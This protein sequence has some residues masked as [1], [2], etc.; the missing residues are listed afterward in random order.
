MYAGGLGVKKDEAKAFQL[1]QAAI[2]E[3]REAIAAGFAGNEEVEKQARE[4]MET[5]GVGR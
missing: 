3:S 4:A 1:Y 5:L 2:R